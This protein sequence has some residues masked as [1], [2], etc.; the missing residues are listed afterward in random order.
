[1]YT[2]A[3]QL[4]ERVA[5]PAAKGAVSRRWELEALPSSTHFLD[6]IPGRD[7]LFSAE[8]LAAGTSAPGIRFLQLLC[9]T[10]CHLCSRRVF[11]ALLRASHTHH[12]P[13]GQ[14]QRSVIS[15]FNAQTVLY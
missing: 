13:Y 2:W 5:V 4:A 8:T 6:Y 12:L 9:N 14:A 11:W 3:W 10:K 7:T 1:M 15:Y